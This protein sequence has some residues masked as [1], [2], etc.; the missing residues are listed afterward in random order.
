MINPSAAKD[1][2]II[3]RRCHGDNL[4][5]GMLRLMSS[6]ICRWG[7]FSD[8]N[9]MGR[10]YTCGAMWQA[11]GFLDPSAEVNVPQCRDDL[12]EQL[13]CHSDCFIAGYK[14]FTMAARLDIEIVNLDPISSNVN[15]SRIW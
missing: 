10:L 7:S 1:P 6:R 8:A 3:K 12:R 14:Q 15:L 4:P 2:V 9:E 13:L 5:M 11:G